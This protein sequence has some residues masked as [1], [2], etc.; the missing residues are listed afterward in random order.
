MGIFGNLMI[1]CL[2]D[3]LIRKYLTSVGVYIV[4][5]CNLQQDC[6]LHTHLSPL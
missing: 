3:Y 2:G 4:S 5:L 6:A 1:D